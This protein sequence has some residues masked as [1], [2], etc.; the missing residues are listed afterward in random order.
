MNSDYKFL[1]SE[2]SVD[3]EAIDL[4]NSVNQD[5]IVFFN[6]FQ[7]TLQ[8]FIQAY[9]E[10]DLQKFNHISRDLTPLIT[11]SIRAETFSELFD[12][13]EKSSLFSI[14]LNTFKDFAFQNNLIIPLHSQV[15]ASTLFIISALTEYRDCCRCFYE[16]EIFEYL[17][18]YLQQCSRSKFQRLKVPSLYA[19]PL[20]QIFIN[21]AGNYEA[22]T[23][24]TPKMLLFIVNH[25]YH[26]KQSKEYIPIMHFFERYWRHS[27]SLCHNDFGAIPET[28]VES[29]KSMFRCLNDYFCSNNAIFTLP[30]TQRSAYLEHLSH[31]LYQMSLFENLQVDIFNK[32]PNDI[33]IFYQKFWADH[34]LLP[35][36]IGKF[37]C[38]WIEFFNEFP[39]FNI[40]LDTLFNKLASIDLKESKRLADGILSSLINILAKIKSLLS[41]P[42]M[43][44]IITYLFNIYDT[45]DF[46]LKPQCLSLLCLIFSDP[47]RLTQV[48][49][50]SIF[51]FFI[52]SC[53]SLIMTNV[54]N[55]K[56]QSHRYIFDFLN[57]LYDFIEKH[58]ELDP[59][60]SE[61]FNESI[62]DFPNYFEPGEILPLLPFL[63]QVPI[64]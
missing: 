55:V 16:L 37:A 10:K 54:T 25:V 6:Q 35:I 48:N 33:L 56:F 18:F 23:K 14:L 59:S 20:L 15:L 49:D 26:A 12:S 45:V 30:S 61:N 2:C 13:V 41:L 38:N 27:R 39:K 46:D 53:S 40:T 62:Q 22:F 11:Y 42:I 9:Q 1:S 47:Q 44:S 24:F 3:T 57:I 5:K 17:Q 7:S 36:S 19:N 28:Y 43:E 4:I 29:F 8:Q 32:Y 58:P 50:S 63:N 64:K 31:L 60:I 34:Y 51:E 21:F 52:N